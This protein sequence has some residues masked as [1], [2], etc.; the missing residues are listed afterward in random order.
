ML[1]YAVLPREKEVHFSI[2]SK[3]SFITEIILHKIMT[4]ACELPLNAHLFY[5]KFILNAF[6]HILL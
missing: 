1:Q 5:F 3:R 4:P 6:F 2:L